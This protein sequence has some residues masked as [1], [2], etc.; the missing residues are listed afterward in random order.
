[1]HQL[2]LC[3]IYGNNKYTHEHTYIPNKTERKSNT[4]TSSTNMTLDFSLAD[5]QVDGKAH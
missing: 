2:Q 3:R 4:N 1:M 5:F